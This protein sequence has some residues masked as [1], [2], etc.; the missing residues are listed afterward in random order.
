MIL[1]RQRT[2]LRKRLAGIPTPT[3]NPCR[4]QRHLTYGA[5]QIPFAL[6]QIARPLLLLFVPDTERLNGLAPAL[7]EVCNAR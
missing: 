4:T 7:S 1:R 6:P 3:T 5:P 2:S